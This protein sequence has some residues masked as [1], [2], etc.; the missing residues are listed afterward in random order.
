M[1]LARLGRKHSEEVKAK[2]GLACKK[3]FADPT[4]VEKMKQSGFAV[5]RSR[6]IKV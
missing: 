3:N 2:I 6:K 1:R 5:G 4:Y